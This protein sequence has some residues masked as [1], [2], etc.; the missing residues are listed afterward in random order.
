MNHDIDRDLK[1]EAEAATEALR[2]PCPAEKWWRRFGA[3][4]KQSA[5]EIVADR[6]ADR[7]Q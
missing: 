1:A 4:V 7:D 5:Q 3:E 2:E 6:M